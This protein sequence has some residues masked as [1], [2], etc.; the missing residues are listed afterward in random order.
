MMAT[1]Q[2]PCRECYIQC[3]TCRDPTITHTHTQTPTIDRKVCATGILYC[4]IDG[5]V[6]LEVLYNA[7]DQLA[8]AVAVAVV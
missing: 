8:V 1:I 5:R 3:T 2:D 7:N 6:W 4:T